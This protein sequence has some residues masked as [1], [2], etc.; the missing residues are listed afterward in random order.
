[1]PSVVLPGGAAD[2]ETAR[3]SRAEAVAKY[4]IVGE[5]GGLFGCFT[6][7]G[8]SFAADG[9]SSRGATFSVWK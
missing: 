5:S 3:A 1:M 8:N 6:I 9:L 4:F 7:A 2:K